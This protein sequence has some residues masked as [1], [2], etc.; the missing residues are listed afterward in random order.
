MRVDAWR[1]HALPAGDVARLADLA[2]SFA[3]DRWLA[4]VDEVGGELAREPLL[5]GIAT[6]AAR[7]EITDWHLDRARHVARRVERTLPL[8]EAPRT[9][10][11][12]GEAVV[13]LSRRAA[14]AVLCELLLITAVLKRDGVVQIAPSPN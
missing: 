3:P 6:A 8:P 1:I 12:L 11:Q 14:A 5:A 13:L 2:A 4:L 9:S 10:Q 7:T